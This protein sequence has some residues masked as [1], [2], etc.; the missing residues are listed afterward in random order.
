M[1]KQRFRFD[2]IH[3]AQIT[4]CPEIVW[5]RKKMPPP[6]TG[7]RHP[8]LSPMVVTNGISEIVWD[9]LCF[10][11]A[12]HGGQKAVKMF[13]GFDTTSCRGRGGH[14]GTPHGAP[15]R[16]PGHWASLGRGSWALSHYSDSSARGVC[17]QPAESTL[18]PAGCQKTNEQILVLSGCPLP[19]PYTCS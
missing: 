13:T 6:Q 15:R 9:K 16:C 19:S 17:W 11:A 3:L 8:D 7:C 1:L 4:Q 14:A 2:F 12:E 5:V 18:S 10:K